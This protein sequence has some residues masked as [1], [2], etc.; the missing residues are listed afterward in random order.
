MHILPAQEQ[1]LQ[2]QFPFN[3]RSEEPESHNS[4]IV[5]QYLRLKH[6]N[7]CQGDLAYLGATMRSKKQICVEFTSSNCWLCFKAL[8]NI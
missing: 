7:S 1:H 5:R 4:S 3:N 6:F 2:E 8:V